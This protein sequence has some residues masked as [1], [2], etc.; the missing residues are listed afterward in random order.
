MEQNET[1]QLFG[2]SIEPSAKSHLSEAA[3]WA[4]FLSIIGF[5]ILGILM[6]A[7]ILSIAFM[8]GNRTTPTI[9]EAFPASQMES[10]GFRYL[11]AVIYIVLSVLYFFPCLFL[12]RFANKM[13]TALAANDQETLNASFQ[14]LKIL[15]RFAGIM[16]IVIIAFYLIIFLIG[17]IAVSSLPT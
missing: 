13:K 6:F 17:I 1:T 11:F 16:T 9:S 12:L 15:F 3:K 4:K 5:V 2:L 8:G 10:A 14:N 7:G